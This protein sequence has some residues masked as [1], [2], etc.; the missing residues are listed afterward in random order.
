MT[1]FCTAAMI[2]ALLCFLDSGVTRRIAYDDDSLADSLVLALRTAVGESGGTQ[3]IKFTLEPQ[4]D[5][6]FLGCINL[7]EQVVHQF[8]Q[9]NKH[10]NPQYSELWEQK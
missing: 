6:Q 8:N 7:M 1:H 5:R 3:Y 4:I 2:R 10:Q 9:I